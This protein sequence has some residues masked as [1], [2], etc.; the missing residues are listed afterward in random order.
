MKVVEIKI[1][2]DSE[3]I[4]KYQ[5]LIGDFFYS[6]GI[7]GLKLEEPLKEKNT[8]DFYR[9]EKDF[10]KINYSIS[11]YFPL[12][13]YA[14]KREEVLRAEFDKIFKEDEDVVYQMEFYQHDEEDYENSWKQYFF[15]QKIS[16]KFVVKPTWREYEAKDNELII[17]LDPGKAFGTGAH[18]TTSLALRLMEKYVEK[19]SKVLDVGTGTGILLIGASKLGAMKTVGI[20]IDDLA[21]ESAIEN[22]KLNNISLENNQVF[23]GD[24]LS[25]VQAEQFDIVVANILADV[26]ILLLK[27]IKKVIGSNGIIL[28]SGIIKEKYQLIKNEIEKYN[29][30]IIEEISEEDWIAIAINEK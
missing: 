12:N 22:L 24:L 30:K 9:N 11:A 3:N 10:L 23:K 29:L 28:F 14:K 2:F 1:I 13:A 19:E 21:V 4:I 8:L 20:D 15:T 26:L 16:E 25:V 7:Q 17:K 6:F 5:K 27:D 18:P